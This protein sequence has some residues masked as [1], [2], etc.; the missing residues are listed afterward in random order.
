Y[1]EW[2]LERLGLQ[3]RV[4]FVGV[5]S[6][7]RPWFAAADVF[8]LPSREDPFPLVCLEA[9][10]AGTPIVCFDAGGMPEL[11]EPSGGGIVVP[12]P[13]VDAMG[14]AVASLL[15]D[16]GRRADAGAA[17]SAAVRAGYL[18]EHLAPRLLEALEATA[19]R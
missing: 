3:D 18:T 17:A 6:D 2:E 4:H 16:P 13:D 12:Y 7:P 9:G 5:R 14:E 1:V 11:V 15:D 8:L 10:A 19:R